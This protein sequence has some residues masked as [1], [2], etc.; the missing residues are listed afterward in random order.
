MQIGKANCYIETTGVTFAD[1]EGIN[2]A[3]AAANIASIIFMDELDAL[4]KARGINGA[5]IDSQSREDG[6][7]EGKKEIR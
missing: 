5:T 1:V 3:E 2:E 4:A 6:A 7:G